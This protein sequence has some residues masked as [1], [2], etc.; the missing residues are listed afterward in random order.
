MDEQRF[1]SAISSIVREAP[2]S[3]PS[4]VDIISTVHGGLMTRELKSAVEA[5][6]EIDSSIYLVDRPYRITQ[7]RL[8][9]KVLNPYVFANL[10]NY[11][12]LSLMNRQGNSMGVL[13]KFLKSEALPIYKVLIEERA[14]YMAKL[15][16]DQARDNETVV[17]VC[18]SLHVPI[19]ESILSAP[20]IDEK[21]ARTVNM[22]EISRK[23]LPLWPI[24]VGVYFVIPMSLG[25][26]LWMMAVSG[27]VGGMKKI[28]LGSSDEN[29]TFRV[30]NS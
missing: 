17:V 8:A 18:S 10:F 16:H 27:L 3:Q 23:G 22:N 12:K 6:R 4:R 30:S 5:A 26:Y 14:Q 9:E 15:I 25:V 1:Q 7:N 28:L 13:E 21:I 24:L 20:N 29:N 2:M 11:G 19:I